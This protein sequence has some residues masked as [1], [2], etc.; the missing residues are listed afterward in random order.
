[1]ERG[2]GADRAMEGAS[3]A[4]LGVVFCSICSPARDPGISRKDEPEPQPS[5][6]RR[7]STLYEFGYLGM[8]G[9]GRGRKG[10]ECE[11]EEGFAG[12]KMLH[13][14]S[15][16]HAGPQRI[17]RRTKVNSRYLYARR[18][19]FWKVVPR[20]DRNSVCGRAAEDGGQSRRNREEWQA[21]REAGRD[22]CFAC[23]EFRKCHRLGRG[24]VCS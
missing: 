14:D 21:R 13:R 18:T 17:D 8:L 16:K 11:L 4:V 20:V 9:R 2:L 6:P 24:G 23:K 10:I 7:G 5:H 12:R 22:G 3:G 15:V 19:S 1:V